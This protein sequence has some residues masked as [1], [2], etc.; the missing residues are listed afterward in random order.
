MKIKQILVIKET[1]DG[2]S[3]VALTPKTVAYSPLILFL[4][5]ASYKELLS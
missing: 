2:E 3:R 1:S 4:E 5:L